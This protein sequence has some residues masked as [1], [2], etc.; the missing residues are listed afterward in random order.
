MQDLGQLE[1]LFLFRHGDY[2]VH[3]KTGEQTLKGDYKKDSRPLVEAIKVRWNFEKSFGLYVSS[4]KRTSLSVKHVAQGLQL[5]PQ[6]PVRISGL[7][8]SSS[9]S[10]LV[11][12]QLIE[13]AK[14]D[15]VYQ[16]IV[17]GSQAMMSGTGLIMAVLKNLKEDREE[18]RKLFD[19]RRVTYWSGFYID[20][21]T[22]EWKKIP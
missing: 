12:N 3:E 17:C 6:E 20:L 16:G 5:I 13:S 19:N 10:P 2:S 21:K 18:M 15:G 8:A 14:R 9:Y 1:R 7:S 4:E 22:G 11:Y